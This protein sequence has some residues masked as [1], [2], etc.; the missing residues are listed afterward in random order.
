MSVNPSLSSEIEHV[1]NGQAEFETETVDGV[2]RS[3]AEGAVLV[4]ESER[5]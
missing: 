2:Q 3:E 1:G 5:A 4:K